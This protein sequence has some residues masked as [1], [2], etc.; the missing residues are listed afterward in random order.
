MT[1]TVSATLALIALVD[2]PSRAT[3][4]RRVVLYQQLAAQQVAASA[5]RKRD[6]AA[7]GMSVQRP[8]QVSVGQIGDGSGQCSEVS[9]IDCR[10]FDD[11][12]HA[13]DGIADGPVCHSALDS[14]LG[15]DQQA[16]SVM[17]GDYGT[18]NSGSP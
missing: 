12:A 14:A 16:V 1:I 8:S 3:Q 10:L 2:G 17:A 6:A 9:C 5:A 11:V 18:Y 13:L 7:G 4:P 15:D